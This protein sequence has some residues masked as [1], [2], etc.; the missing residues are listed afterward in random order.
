LVVRFDQQLMV[1]CTSHLNQCYRVQ[2]TIISRHNAHG[3]KSWMT[4]SAGHV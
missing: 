1:H 2:A 3:V 4:L